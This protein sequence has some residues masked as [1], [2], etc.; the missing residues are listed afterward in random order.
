MDL[1][2]IKTLTLNV[3]R[4]PKTKAYFALGIAVIGM[5][6]AVDEILKPADEEADGDDED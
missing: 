1:K 5:I 4:S 6:R 2:D 3:L